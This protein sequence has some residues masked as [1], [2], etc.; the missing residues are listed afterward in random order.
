[1]RNE[2]IKNI[3]EDKDLKQYEFANELG[4]SPKTYSAYENGLRS[5]PVPTLNKILDKLDISLDY[6]FGF[7]LEK[8]YDDSKEIDL[9]ILSSRI[10]EVRMNKEYSQAKMANLIGVNQ[11]TLSE[12]EIGNISMP[13]STLELFCKINKVSADYMTG[14]IDSNPL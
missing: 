9:K 3:R 10:K 7:S 1:M 2:I 13:L 5:I 4:I 11:Q 8:N 14:R 6:L 12:Y